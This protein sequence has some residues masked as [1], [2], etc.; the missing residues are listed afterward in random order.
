LSR[1]YH[2][3]VARHAADAEARWVDNLLA[4]FAIPGIDSGGQGTSR[5][6]SSLGI[7]HVALVSRLVRALGIALQ[8]ASALA[9][10]LM[11]TPP[12][13]AVF[14]IGE[15]ELRFDRAA[16]VASVDAR[17]ADAVESVVPPKR[18]RPPRDR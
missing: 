14:V 3:D 16:F 1:S 12:G 13:D 10:R 9:A 11:A 5:R 7:Y 2:V 15:L 17:I 4:R 6:I 18:G 8:P